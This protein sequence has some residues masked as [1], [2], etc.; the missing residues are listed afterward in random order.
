M[1]LKL[2]LCLLGTF[3][4]F[5][6]GVHAQGLSFADKT[7]IELELLNETDKPKNLR[8]I[9]LF[10]SSTEQFTV[11]LELTGFAF[12]ESNDKEKAEDD[13]I[14]ETS[15]VLQL[16][17]GDLTNN[18]SVSEN[19]GNKQNCPNT[20]V[21]IPAP[22][23]ISLT[24]QAK[25]QSL[26]KVKPG[27]YSG[28]ISAT[29]ASKPSVLLP[30]V[31]KVPDPSVLV[32]E[33]TIQRFR[34]LPLENCGWSCDSVIP[35]KDLTEDDKC[36]DKDSSYT[37]IN[38]RGDKAIVYVTEDYEVKGCSFNFIGDYKSLKPVTLPKGS[39]VSLTV[40]VT[41]N[42]FLPII[43]VILG[44]AIAMGI[45]WFNEIG[46]KW[47][48]LKREFDKQCPKNYCQNEF[49]ENDR[50]YNYSASKG[51]RDWCSQLR[52]Q[53]GFNMKLNEQEY[54][55]LKSE[56]ALLQKVQEEWPKFVQNLDSLKDRLCE[57]QNYVTTASPPP[58]LEKTPNFLEE[59]KKLFEGHELEMSE[60]KEFSGENGHHHKILKALKLTESWENLDTK[61][62]DYGG[63]LQS[64]N[65]QNIQK[66]T[67]NSLEQ[68][69]LYEAQEL[70]QEA[71]QELWRAKNADE[72]LEYATE[73]DL[74]NVESKLFSLFEH[75][76]TLPLVNKDGKQQTHFAKEPLT[77]GFR[78][79]GNSMNEVIQS[80]FKPN[81][82]QIQT[83]AN[84]LILSV[85]LFVA[86]IGVLE[87]LYIGK[88]FG[89]AWDYV[90][91]FAA[92]LGSVVATD[93][94]YSAVQ[95]VMGV[96]QN[97]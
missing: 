53:M 23:V 41:D 32:T 44:L 92:G 52:Q 25:P 67:L 77:T 8:T 62:R 83:R 29:I 72:L 37:L 56:V 55:S 1:R 71:R 90:R 46:N 3:S 14:V 38:T 60:V 39:E 81:T 87:L 64:L 74:K 97:I 5:Q 13:K 54:L 58:L 94:I 10:N 27:T 85:G 47:L 45:R 36:H 82:K 49:G 66:T 28:Y 16:W 79:F 93:L 34:Q 57:V 43:T 50:P 78:A 12:K 86:I 2:L 76:A 70:V 75:L 21:I 26:K 9:D 73:N 17:C 69:R 22:G 88:P 65:I 48:T 95:R 18:K 35:V 68:Q 4:F 42:I 20:E 91:A 51:L 96:K 24:L 89:T 84:W 61:A 19:E 59:A 40:R 31:I 15:E 33:W 6:G 63:W 30:V 7:P 11:K 80:V